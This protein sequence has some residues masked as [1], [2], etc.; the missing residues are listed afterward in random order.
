[1]NMMQCPLRISRSVPGALPLR[2]SV[3]IV[4]V[5]CGIA[6]DYADTVTSESFAVEKVRHDGVR[7]ADR[8]ARLLQHARRHGGAARRH[9]HPLGAE[10]HRSDVARRADED[11]A[12]RRGL[13]VLPAAR[14]IP[15]PA[16]CIRWAF[17]T[18][19]RAT[20][21]WPTASGWT[22]RAAHL[23]AAACSSRRGQARPRG[24]RRRGLNMANGVAIR[25]GFVYVTD[26]ATGKT[27]DGA[28]S[29]AVY[30]FRLDERDVAGQARR[31]RS[32]P[33]G[34]PEDGLQ[35]HPSRRRW[36]RFRRARQPVRGQLR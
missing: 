35:G 18:R 20:S 22:R 32:A 21:T 34:D 33:G 9:G 29:S 3:L 6:T 8:P 19:R 2:I 24:C 7:R 23:A 5:S 27:A 13:A 14:C 31:R 30:R 11:H 4:L 17:A 12:Q 26:S 1:M 36:D 28:V 25:D 10:L 16:R 15:K